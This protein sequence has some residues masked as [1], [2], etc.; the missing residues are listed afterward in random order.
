MNSKQKRPKFLNLFAIHLPVTGITSFAHRVS[1]ALMILALPGLIYLFGLSVRDSTGFAATLSILHAWPVKLIGTLLGWTI[2]HHVLA[3]I[4]FLLM[5]ID[6]GEQLTTAK[7]TAWLVNVA[8]VVVFL[9]IAIKIW[10]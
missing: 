9:L 10:L 3:G 4:R 2:V 7:I 1:G 6:I 5:D 8:G